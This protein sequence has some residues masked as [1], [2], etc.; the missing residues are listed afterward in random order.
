MI[1]AKIILYAITFNKKTSDYDVI[2]DHPET[3]SECYTIINDDIS[4]YDQLDKLFIDYF[5]FQ[6]QFVKTIYL[7]P[8]IKN[9]VLNIPIFCLVPYSIELKKGY[10]ISVKQHAIHISSIRKILNLI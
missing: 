5:D 4:F 3:F 2:S 9:S 10:L 6:I 8:F 1:K 7:E